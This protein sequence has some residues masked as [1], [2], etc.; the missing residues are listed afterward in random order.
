MRWV[1]KIAFVVIVTAL[2]WFNVAAAIIAICATLLAALHDKASSIIELSFGPLKAKLERELSDAEK[3][4]S[5]L[6]RLAAIQAR[7]AIAASAR[8]GRFASGN[9]WIFVATKRTEAA[10]REIGVSEDELKEARSDL[11]ALT[12][13]DLGR[14]V[15]GGSHVPTH[16]SKEA[17]EELRRLN[18]TKRI[19]EPAEVEAWL[20]KWDLLVPVRQSL[21]EDMRW[22]AEHQDI[23]D[24]A[25]YMRAHTPIDWEAN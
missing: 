21:I 11:V 15:T 7:Q 9:D 24:S 1:L 20:R 10:L 3:L 13:S 4:V 18:E 23:R 22:I 12:L 17:Q 6:K 19:S 2:A 16:L 14:M 8:T 5:K 25:Q